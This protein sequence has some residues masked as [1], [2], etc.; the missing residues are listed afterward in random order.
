MEE[1]VNGLRECGGNVVASVINSTSANFI[2][3]M[4]RNTVAAGS[5]LC[6]D[7]HSSYTGMPE[8]VH[9]VVNHSVKQFVDVMAHTNGIESVWAVLKR[10]VYHQFSIKHPQCYV[11]EFA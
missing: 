3:A 6:T 5:I 4:V 11:D 9:H 10:D 7:E 1:A 2:R 8:Y